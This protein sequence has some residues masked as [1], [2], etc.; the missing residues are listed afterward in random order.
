ML[1]GFAFKKS[2]ITESKK[3]SMVTPSSSKY[4]IQGKPHPAESNRIV[5]EFEKH[6]PWVFF[7][8]LRWVVQI[9][10]RV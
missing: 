2:E 3:I 7:Y 6:F 1:T 5:L 10:Q 4:V 9:I 8:H